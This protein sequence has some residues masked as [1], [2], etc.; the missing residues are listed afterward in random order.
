VR[1]HLIGQG[2]AAKRLHAI[3]YGEERK[4]DNADTEAAH[5]RNRRANFR[6]LN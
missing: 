3:S 4:L 5:A 1:K 6:V 2:I